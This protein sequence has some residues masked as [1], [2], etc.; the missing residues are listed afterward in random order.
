MTQKEVIAEI[1]KIA[2]RSDS[3]KIGETGQTLA[4]R[5]KGHAANFRMIKG[6]TYSSDP[7]KIDALESKMLR[8]FI[9]HPKCVNTN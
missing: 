9:N 1:L 4:D 3:F 2:K 7:K 8:I 5:G 6:I